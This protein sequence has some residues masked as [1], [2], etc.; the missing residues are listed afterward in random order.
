MPQRRSF[1]RKKAPLGARRCPR[2]GVPMFLVSIE[3][4]DQLDHDRRTFECS[5]CTYHEVVTVMLPQRAGSRTGLLRLRGRVTMKRT[6][7][8]IIVLLFSTPI[9]AAE[10][11]IMRDLTTQKC[12]VVDKRPVTALRT[13][14]LASDAIYKSRGDAE[15]AMSAI[16]VCSSQK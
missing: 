7:V 9:W 15:S 10:F 12:S 11:Y 14:T 5:S 16:K 6:L 4:T 13:I 3:P 1:A 2:C 8:A